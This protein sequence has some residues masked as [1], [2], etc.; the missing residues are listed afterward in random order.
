MQLKAAEEAVRIMLTSLGYDVEAEGL[1]DTP[2]RYVKALAEFTKQESFNW[3]TFAAEG[4]QEM[5]VQKHIPFFSLC[6]HHLLPFFGIAHVAY[7]PNEKIVGLSKLA[8]CVQYHARQLQNQERITS[9]VADDL[10][11][12]LAPKGAAVRLEAR[13]LCMEMRGVKTHDAVTQTTALRGTFLT[14]PEVRHEF[15]SSL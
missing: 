11:K 7:I 10:M 9:M 12:N 5:V 2:R 8:R 13:H 1:R 3:T 15:L 4:M 14:H 6:E